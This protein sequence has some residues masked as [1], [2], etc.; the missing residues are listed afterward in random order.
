MWFRSVFNSEKLGAATLLAALCWSVALQRTS[1]QQRHPRVC[2]DDGCLLGISMTDVNDHRF[3][4][5]LGVPFAKPPVGELRFKNPLPVEPLIGDYNATESGPA[6]LQRSELD[7]DHSIIGSEDCLYL[8]VYRPKRDG[9]DLLPVMV[10]IHGGGYFYGS[11][12]PQ[13][14]G[15]ERILAT[16]RVLLVTIQYRLGVFGFLS[17]GDTVVPGNAGMHDQVLALKWVQRHI[18]PFGGNPDQVT[19]FGESAGGA[20]VQFHMISPLSRSLF[21]K[22]IIMSGSALAAWSLPIDDPLALARRQAKLL[23]ITEADELTS[24]E[25]VDV[26]R[27][28]DGNVLVASAPHLRTWFEHPI[29]LYRP[30]IEHKSVPEAER[31]LPDD[32]RRLWTEGYLVDVPLL[33]GTVP[34]DGAV[35]S[36]PILHNAT[37]LQELNEN[38]ANLL[39]TL[40]AVNGT[41]EVVNQIKDRYFKGSTPSQLITAE[42]S[43]ELTKLFTDAFLKYPVYLS[44]LEYINATSRE[45]TTQYSFEFVGRHSFSS[46]YIQSNES[47]GVV[48]QDELI[49]LFRMPELFNDFPDGSAE[50]KMSSL[51]TD[52]FVSFAS[53]SQPIERVEKVTFKNAAS[54]DSSTLISRDAAL[55]AE[56]LDVILFWDEIYNSSYIAYH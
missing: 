24:T 2:T 32:P 53:T 45:Q 29:I 42:N 15:P 3:D 25:L 30:V 40:L 19:I 20:S 28:I 46:L 4:A 6:C 7:P 35:V 16:Q 1:A 39:P 38:F 23:G 21:H 22:A 14:F 55:D 36:L 47:H 27:Y 10:Y 56:M 44:Q 34:E 33:I 54:D 11:A 17:T 12:D 49:Y 37:A 43:R 51:W 50:A 8:N 13:L 52:F 26:L 31:F 18:R 9:S 48:H 41:P 5:F